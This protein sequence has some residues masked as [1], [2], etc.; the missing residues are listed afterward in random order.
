MRL[1]LIASLS[2]VSFLLL[3]CGQPVPTADDEACEHLAEGPGTAVTAVAGGEGP[4][5][6]DDHRRYDVTLVP[7]SGGNGG[8]IRF[9]ADEPGDFLFF[10]SAEVDFT[11]ST[12]TGDAILLE[13]LIPGSEVC[14]AVGAKWIFHLEVGTYRL[15]LGPTS[16]TLLSF[17]VEHGGAHEEHTE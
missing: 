8:Q 5:I 10:T 16:E 3:A 14:D 6:A 9:A 4:L 13:E 17:V 15:E 7:V 1:H 2:S 12:L 11:V